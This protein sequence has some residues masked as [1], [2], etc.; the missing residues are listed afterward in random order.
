MAEPRHGIIRSI[1]LRLRQADSSIPS[2]IS[3]IQ[4]VTISNDLYGNDVASAFELTKGFTS[5]I[6][7]ESGLRSLPPEICEAR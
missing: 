5:P 2:D 6:S 1:Y 7:R 4:A 3:A